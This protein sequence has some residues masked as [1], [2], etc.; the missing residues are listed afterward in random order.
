MFGVY[1]VIWFDSFLFI[2]VST[3]GFFLHGYHACVLGHFSY[4]HLCAT[5]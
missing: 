3:V 5:L 2:F 1:I 4:V